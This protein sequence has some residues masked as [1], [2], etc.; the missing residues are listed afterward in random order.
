MVYR[1][2]GARPG[3]W[4]RNS[5]AEMRIHHIDA[6]EIL[7]GLCILFVKLKSFQGLSKVSSTTSSP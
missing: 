3:G 5:A 2:V 4:R 6:A 1:T 7:A